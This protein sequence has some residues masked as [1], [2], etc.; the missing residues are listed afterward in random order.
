MSQIEV[1]RLPGTAFGRF[2]YQ[3]REGARRQGN[4]VFAL[5]FRDLKSRSG[6][7]SYG[8][9]SLVGILLEPA[10][11]VFLMSMF[12]YLLRRQEVQGVSIFL[13]LTV[14]ITAFTI[15]RRSIATIP[16]A[17]RG[18]RAFYTFPNVKPFDVAL[19]RF[20][21]EVVL[22]LLG[23]AILL[24]LLWWFRD[25]AIRHDK[26]LEGF[27]ILALLM[28]AGFGLSLFLG[29]Y[30]TIFPAVLKV[31][32]ATGRILFFVSCV[33]HAAIELPPEAQTVLIWNPLAHAMELLRYETLGIRPFLHVSYGYFAGFAAICLFL[34]F[35]AYYPNR[36]KV[37][38]R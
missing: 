14:S 3:L 24:F 22:T 21:I 12:Y 1:E 2:F 36:F 29:I 9:L 10:I 28:V 16:R 33:I 32:A 34:G 15:I 37:L 13:F 4:V 11:T 30:G 26:L 35:I 5:I 19:A 25:E 6:Q 7:E 23:G 27:G 17:L 18:S 8:L 20:I 38:E 31:V